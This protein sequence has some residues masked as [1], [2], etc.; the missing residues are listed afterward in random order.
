MAPDFFAQKS[1]KATKFGRKLWS[2][3]S[4]SKQVRIEFEISTQ[5]SCIDSRSIGSFPL[6][7]AP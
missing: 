7:R 2:A 4:D 5:I 1:W 3:L 6:R